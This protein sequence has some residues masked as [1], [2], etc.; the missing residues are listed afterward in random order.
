M[1]KTVLG[2][3]LVAY[4]A[5]HSPF[6]VAWLRQTWGVLVAVVSTAYNA[7]LARG[8]Y[9]LFRDCR[10]KTYIAA[11]VATVCAPCA[12]YVYIYWPGISAW[13]SAYV[14]KRDMTQK[15]A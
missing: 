9:P 5:G 2:A 14:E 1:F 6:I 8:F 10:R 4:A 15:G 3:L 7:A 13:L 11:G 12:I